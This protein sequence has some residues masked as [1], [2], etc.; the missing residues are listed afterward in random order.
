VATGLLAISLKIG[1]KNEGSVDTHNH[2]RIY[3]SG[4]FN[5]KTR[6]SGKMV[7]AEVVLAQLNVALQPH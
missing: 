5:G 7:S 6:A 4:A 2:H 3:L 1:C